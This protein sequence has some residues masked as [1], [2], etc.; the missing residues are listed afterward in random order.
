MSKKKEQLKTFRESIKK[1][2]AVV[3]CVNCGSTCIDQNSQNQLRCYSCDNTLDTWNSRKFSIVR[4]SGAKEPI[5]ELTDVENLFLEI[6]KEN[7]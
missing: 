3:F 2:A 1:S 6:D 4:T 5:N 7:K